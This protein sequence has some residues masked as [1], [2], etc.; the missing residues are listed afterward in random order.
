MSGGHLGN[1][2]QPQTNCVGKK[3]RSLLPCLSK[4]IFKK[5]VCGG[6]NGLM[7]FSFTSLGDNWVHILVFWFA[8]AVT[9]QMTLV[10]QGTTTVLWLFT[11]LSDSRWVLLNP[12]MWREDKIPFVILWPLWMETSTWKRIALQ[13]WRFKNEIHQLICRLH[14]LCRVV[15][16]PR[17]SPQRANA[18][19]E[20]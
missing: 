15:V 13:R 7:T 20:E 1:F 10:R 12:Q 2:L 4:S 8:S 14:I 19:R 9:E 5:N 6:W 3:Q 18:G 16:T 11:S 17:W